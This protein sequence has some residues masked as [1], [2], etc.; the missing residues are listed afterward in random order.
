MPPGVAGGPEA[1]PRSKVAVLDVDGTLYSGALGVELLRA[2]VERAACDVERAREV[3]DLVARY[4][5]GEIDHA[6]LSAEAYLA[7]GRTLAGASVEEVQ[8]IARSTWQQERSG[9]FPFVGSLVATLKHKGFTVVLISGSPNEMICEIAADVGAPHFCGALFAVKGGVY[10][11]EASLRS[12]AL[13]AKSDI[14]KR[15]LEG[16]DVDLAASFAMGD[17][18][19]DVALFQ[20]IGKPMT[21][22]PTPELLAVARENGWPVASRHDVLQRLD[23]LLD[24]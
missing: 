17:S 21:F 12:G 14:L 7:Y 3:F 5:R 15:L 22:E 24:G 2:L 6:T 13:G 18:L 4:R 8:R 16:D 23:E 11:G 19:A 1:G 20:M 10:T 9:L